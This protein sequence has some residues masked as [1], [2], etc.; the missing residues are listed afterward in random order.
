MSEREEWTHEIPAYRVH[1]VQW[2]VGVPH[3][4]VFRGEGEA[5]RWHYINVTRT[6]YHLYG[7]T[8]HP[9]ETRMMHAGDWIVTHPDGSIEVLGDYDMQ[10]RFIPR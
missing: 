6:D 1:A 5:D 4:L 2:R 7:S 8:E 9:P 10:R 3:P